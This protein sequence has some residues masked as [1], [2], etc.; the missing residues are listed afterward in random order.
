MQIPVIP[1]IFLAILNISIIDG[2]TK[3]PHCVE[4]EFWLT[5]MGLGTVS[6]NQLGRQFACA[7]CEQQQLLEALYESRNGVRII[8][9]IF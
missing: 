4:V 2:V 7:L 6:E 9:Q 3:C 8:R 1:A 5:K